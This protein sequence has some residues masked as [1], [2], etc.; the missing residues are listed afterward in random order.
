MVDVEI[1]IDHIIFLHKRKKVPLFYSNTTLC[2][3]R[4]LNRVCQRRTSHRR[5]T[6]SSLVQLLPTLLPS[7]HFLLCSIPSLFVFDCSCLHSC[8]SGETSVEPPDDLSKVQVQHLLRSNTCSSLRKLELLLHLLLLIQLI[9]FFCSSFSVLLQSTLKSLQT[10][11]IS[12]SI[13][14]LCIWNSE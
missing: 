14:I 7:C 8:F 10:Q 13:Y 3:M 4:G 2:P 11:I 9:L 1:K 6:L 5:G 12:Q